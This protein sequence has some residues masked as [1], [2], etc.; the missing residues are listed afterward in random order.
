M[1]T[2]KNNTAWVRLADVIWRVGLAPSRSRARQLMEQGAITVEGQ[3][4]VHVVK[5]VL[6]VLSAEGILHREVQRD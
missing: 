1:E 2:I 3:D 6:A 4:G 5:D